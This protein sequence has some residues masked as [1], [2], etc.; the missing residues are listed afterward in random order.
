MIETALQIGGIA[1]TAMS[2]VIAIIQ[3]IK[4]SKK[5]RIV[6]LAKIV[7]KIPGLINESEELFGE[8]C[9]KAKLNYVLNQLNIEC[10]QNGIEFDKS[11]LA[12]SV[13]N[14]L[15]TPQKKKEQGETQN[16]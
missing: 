10:I 7:Q 5:E 16:G 12:A 13:E 9:G 14:V 1:L 15:S 6:K 2:I 11:G 4:S 8:K 3:S